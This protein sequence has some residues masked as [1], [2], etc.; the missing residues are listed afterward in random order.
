MVLLKRQTLDNIVYTHTSK[1]EQRF[2]RFY[3]LRFAISPKRAA[4]ENG[5]N[6]LYIYKK[7]KDK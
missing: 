7:G 1:N 4:D 3:A 2:K 6:K 5:K